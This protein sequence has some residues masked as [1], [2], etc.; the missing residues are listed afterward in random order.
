MTT[1]TTFGGDVSL[2]QLE[3]DAPDFHAAVVAS[4]ACYTALKTGGKCDLTAYE[5]AGYDSAV[6]SAASGYGHC[7][8]PTYRQMTYCSCVNAPIS[9]AECVFGPCSDGANSYMTTRMLAQMSDA[10]KN[11]PQ[12]VNCQQV[13][14]MGG[15][16]NIASNVAQT[17][18]CG[19]VVNNMITNIQ[20]HPFLAIVVLVLILSVVMLVSGSG[21]SASK[22][23]SKTLPPPQLVM[24]S[25]L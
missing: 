1:Y 7:A 10:A 3:K 8:N 6:G 18:S 19:G 22:G 24:P 17:M 20:A 14:E 23:P 25:T 2:P 21:K 12:A 4:T 5:A 16:G 9:N 15:S 11:C 13:F